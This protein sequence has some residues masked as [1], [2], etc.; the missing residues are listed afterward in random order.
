[1]QTVNGVDDQGIEAQKAWL[2]VPE[3]EKDVWRAR[4]AQA[5]ADWKAAHGYV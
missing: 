4:A 2:A 3:P 1:M 5:I